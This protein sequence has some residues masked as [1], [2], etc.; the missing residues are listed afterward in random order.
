MDVPA[1]WAA[2][3]L[4]QYDWNGTVAGVS[5]VDLDRFLGTAADLAAFTRHTGFAAPAQVNGNDALSV[6]DMGRWPR[7]ALR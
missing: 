6:V 4:W 7:R 2:A 5:P 1:P 3:T